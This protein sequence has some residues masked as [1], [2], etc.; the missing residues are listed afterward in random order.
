MPVTTPPEHSQSSKGIANNWCSREKASEK[1]RCQNAPGRSLM[2][3]REPSIDICR[4]TLCL[5]T[6][7]GSFIS[8]MSADRPDRVESVE[9]FA[10]RTRTSLLKSNQIFCSNI[11]RTFEFT[12]HSASS[13]SISVQLSPTNALGSHW[14]RLV[15]ILNKDSNTTNRKLNLNQTGKRGRF[16]NEG[17]S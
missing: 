5:S 10:K 7:E 4:E 17:P 9:Q 3:G 14:M 12:F 2:S 11:C 1:R 6:I 16:N 8:Q 15:H 13:R